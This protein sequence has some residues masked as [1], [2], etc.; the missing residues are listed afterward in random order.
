MLLALLEERIARGELVPDAAQRTAAERLAKLAEDLAR[1]FRRPAR[2]WLAR[3]AR[4]R[5]A[6][7][8]RGVYLFG[9][10]GRGKSML[11]DLF[12][13]SVPIAAKRRVHFQAFMLEVHRRLDALRRGGARGEPLD[14][15]SRELASVR[16]LCLDELE[17]RDIAD[18]TILGRLFAGLMDAGT[19]LVATSNLPPERLYEGGLNRARFLP[20]IELLRRR[21]DVI[22]LDG[23]VDY[24][25]RRLEGLPLYLYPLG[26]ETEARV[27]RIKAVLGDGAAFA[28]QTL[29]VDGRALVVPEAAPGVAV[30]DFRE[31][32]ARP[33]GPADY[34]ALARRFPAL[35]LERVPLLTPD[36]RNEARRFVTLV[37]AAYEQK[38]I[39]VVSAE[40]E[41]ERLYPEGEGAF[42]FRRTASRLREMQSLSWLEACRTRRLEELPARFTPFALTSDL[43]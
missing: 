35:V 6:A 8:L 3:L 39:L 33:L 30:F 40:A 2:G 19:V 7:P 14:A 28:P 27:A 41:P 9:R 37:D 26:P 24:R 38:Q 5:D 21:L 13:A 15:L 34:L 4:G 16:L 1:A 43:A 18:A 22:A 17:V 29:D 36:R 20:T 25:V 10:P 31:L 12:F 23:P 42:E 32:C 11:V